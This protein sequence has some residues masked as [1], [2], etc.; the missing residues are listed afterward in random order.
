VRN[1][2]LGVAVMLAA[3]AVELALMI[4]R[5]YYPS[6]H[7]VTAPLAVAVSGIEKEAA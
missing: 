5:Q 4:L 6:P 3:D 1:F 2:I 7:R